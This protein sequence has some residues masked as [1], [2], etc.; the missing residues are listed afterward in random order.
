MDKFLCIHGHFYQPPRENPW[1]E[2]IERQDE[3]SPYHDWNERISAECYGP[4]TAS[5]ILDAEK[6]IVAIVNNF[7]R[8]SF[9][10]GPTL[11]SWLEAQDIQ[12]YAAILEAD[13]LSRSRFGGHGA[14]IAQAYNHA[15][16]PLAERRD[17]RTQVVW[18]MADFRRRFGREPEGMWLPETAVD[19]ETLEVLAEEGIGFTVLAP[20]QAVRV[21]PAGG[22]WVDVRGGG[23]DTGMPYRCALPSG[24]SIAL[25]FH[26][27]PISH[28]VSFSDLLRD[29]RSFADR[30]IDALEG[31]D[32]PRLLHIATDGETY[33][34]HHRFGDMALAYCM[35]DIESRG[36]AQVT[37]YGEYL[38]RFPPTW[39]V[40][41]E[42]DSS[43]S[44]VHG[45]ERWR[46]DCGC[47]AGK[48]P[49][50]TQGW[51][52]PLRRALDDLRRAMGDLFEGEAERYLHDPA[53]ARDD[54]IEVINDRSR[55]NVRGFL[56]RWGR[57][58]PSGEAAVKTLR[59]LEMERQAQL[60]YTSCGWF[61]EEIS[62]IETVQIMA[63][64]ARGMQLMRE[65]GGRDPEEDFLRLLENAP[66]NRPEYAHGREVYERCIRSI[67]L[68]DVGVH[69]AIARAVNGGI[70]RTYCFSARPV[71]Y[72]RFESDRVVLDVGE[73]RISSDITWREENVCFAVLYRGGHDLRVGA[74]TGMEGVRFQ[75]MRDDVV[76]SFRTGDLTE[77]IDLME[78][79]FGA[80]TY[81]LKHLFR[82]EQRR[83]IDGILD[84]V[85]R[86]TQA[87]LGGRYEDYL[88]LVQALQ[89]LDAPMPEEF[90]P[91]AEL[92]FNLRLRELLD[93]AM[94]WDIARPS[95]GNGGRESPQE[96]EEEQEDLSL[97]ISRIL[98]HAET[99]GFRL[100]GGSLAKAA[101]NAVER[102][103]ERL[104]L[105]N[106]GRLESTLRLVTALTERPLVLD[107]W[108]SQ[109]RFYALCRELGG[110]TPPGDAPG[111]TPGTAP[112]TARKNQPDAR[113]VELFMRLGERLGVRCARP[114]GA[115]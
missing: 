75:G 108:K 91:M 70:L 63:Y 4:N 84:P 113:W 61:F 93:G 13:R 20:H 89:E 71:T 8:M 6:R 111:N 17:K 35:H 85:I 96:P 101:E 31:G 109:N 39:E 44:C 83:V 69:H 23:V 115:G 52:S 103:V 15:I 48:H 27:G 112:G 18:G 66:S 57:G 47:K 2:A 1:L 80:H 81:T 54:Y 94:T 40:E 25:F 99:F 60:M 86:D 76:E 107:L 82:D 7:T 9:N 98:R 74:R 50:W 41:I 88:S 105:G 87:A 34:H 73:T 28:A 11:L 72:E 55:E 19:L 100:D 30:L 67:D 49:E 53:G 14:A 10:V 78:R 16:M 95:R 106:M 32:G 36:R 77:T 51:R 102:L 92:V 90:R 45:V 58:D 64:A 37:V 46:S 33:G 12:V 43:W 65:I 56:D 5:R 104:T 21:R 62:D 22:E 79:H 24:R 29:G 59:L 38:E 42:E 3:A 97:E 68:V 110:D 114:G 26:H